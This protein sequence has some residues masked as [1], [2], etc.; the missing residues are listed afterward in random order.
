[1]EVVK[2]LINANDINDVSLVDNATTVAAIVLQQVM[3]KSVGAYVD[4]VS[5]F[6]VEVQLPF[7]TC[8]AGSFSSRDLATV[9]APP[10]FLL[11][12]LLLLLL[13]A[14]VVVVVMRPKSYSLGPYDAMSLVF[15]CRIFLHPFERKD[16]FGMAEIFSTK[17]F[18]NHSHTQMKGRGLKL[19]AKE[20]NEE[21]KLLKYNKDININNPMEEN[22]S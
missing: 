12:L 10:L 5:G 7:P 22:P 17:I 6:V 19:G 2:A 4:P 14:I 20:C 21:L 1:M 3:K 16:S 8:V 18:G 15:H 9:I 11:L 13:L